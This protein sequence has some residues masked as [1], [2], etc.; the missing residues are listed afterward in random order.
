MCQE[1]LR[2][3]HILS[4][5]RCV[6]ETEW[7]TVVPAIQSVINNSPSRRLGGLSTIKVNTGMDSGNPFSV[8]IIIA[9]EP[10]VES[11]DEARII[12][13]MK[14]SAILEALYNTH[15]NVGVSLDA[16]RTAA[17]ERRN[18]MTHVKVYKLSEGDYIMFARMHWPR[19]KISAKWVGLRRILGVLN[20]FTVEVEHLLTRKVETVHIFRV[21]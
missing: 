20:D 3:L 9:Q 17:V 5:D 10:V 8:A 4:T 6:P 15:R 12:Q 1:V 2:L 18:R 14:I 11:L 16:S 19:T 7:N 21:Q 13:Q